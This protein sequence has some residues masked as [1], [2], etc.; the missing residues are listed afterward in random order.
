MGVIKIPNDKINNISSANITVPG[1][2]LFPLPPSRR[3]SQ[4][5]SFLYSSCKTTPESVKEAYETIQ[6][7][8][9]NHFKVG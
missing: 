5:K 7:E 9:F 4:V 8:F 2:V 1:T 3:L 6:R